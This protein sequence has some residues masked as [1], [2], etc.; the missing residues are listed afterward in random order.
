MQVIEVSDL[1]KD[2]YNQFIEKQHSSFLQSIEWGDFQAQQNKVSLKY[3]V[4]DNNQIIASAQFF[5]QTIPFI[6]KKF[7]YCPYGPLG[8][9][10]GIAFLLN[11][12]KSLN[13]DFIYIKIEPQQEFNCRGK[14]GSRIQPGITWITDL[15]DNAPDILSSMHHKTR[16]NIN[17]A[18]R[19]NVEIKILDKEEEINEGLKLINN[20]AERQQYKDHNFEY[21]KTLINNLKSS[22]VSNHLYAATYHNKIITSAITIDFLNTRT[23]LFGG[24]N[25]E[26]RKYMAPYLMHWKIIQDAQNIG[27]QKYDWWG[28][29]TS[30]GK[31]AGF[32]DFK[33]KFPGFAI[34]YPPAQD[35]VIK[36]F[37]YQIYKALKLIRNFF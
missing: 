8:S 1:N 11:N 5:I 4:E 17:L 35:I 10:I 13:K 7:L 29:Q 18:Q 33:K 6:N 2:L 34:K 30:S 19:H 27:K 22:Q 24:S 15:T 23:Y 9:K 26:Y 12:L 37:S 28:L 21:Y 25:Y 3:L 16:Y 14:I 20:T 32:S 31:N 36:N